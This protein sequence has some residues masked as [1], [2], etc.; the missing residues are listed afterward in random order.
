MHSMIKLKFNV[1]ISKVTAVNKDK[2][3]LSKLPE[4]LLMNVNTGLR[5]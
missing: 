2:P 1:K 3:G 4:L 5:L